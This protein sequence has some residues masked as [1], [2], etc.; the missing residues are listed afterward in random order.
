MQAAGMARKLG[1]LWRTE[2]FLRELAKRFPKDSMVK[3]RLAFTLES[4]MCLPEARALYEGLRKENPKDVRAYIGLANVAFSLHHRDEAW[5]W[6][7][8][9]AEACAT[10]GADLLAIGHVYLGWDDFTSADRI[11][12]KAQ[13][14][15][16]VNS[17]ITVERGTLLVRSGKPEEANALL[18]ALVEREPRNALAW[19][20]LARV[21]SAS[22]ADPRHAEGADKAAESAVALNPSD[23]EARRY[24]A[25]VFR[26]LGRKR[27]AAQEF[28]QALAASPNHAES[29]YALAQ[30]YGELGRRDWMAEQLETCKRLGEVQHEQQTVVG[31][32]MERPTDWRVRLALGRNKEKQGDFAGAVREYQIAARLSASNREPR[33]ALEGLYDRL[34]WNKATLVQAP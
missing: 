1:D 23:A 22:I 4:E 2:A 34:S 11:L 10:S 25:H 33:A 21:W 30:L 28:A 29:R 26:K 7:E 12:R 18:N 13:D 8:R 19:K 27:R 5:K 20:V 16:P 24:A 31:H 6:L 9:G 17:A 32:A 14:A 15:A 3:T